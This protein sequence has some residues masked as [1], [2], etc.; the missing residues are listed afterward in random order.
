[1]SIIKP[2]GLT[3]YHSHTDY[4][5]GSEKAETMVKAAIEKGFSAWGISSHSPLPEYVHYVVLTHDKVGCYI[6]EVEMLKRK[7][8][9]QIEIYTAM[10]IDYIDEVDNP[11]NE[12]YQSL[13]LDY[14]IGA[15]HFIKQSESE[16][17]DVDTR[18]D[19]FLV[20]LERYY[21]NDLKR[22]VRDYFDTKM[23]MISTGGFD[24]VAHCD[25]ISQNATLTD[26]DITQQR[27][28]IDYAKEY[29]A[30]IAEQ[31]IM[32][33]VNTKSFEREVNLIFPNE[34]FW[35]FIYELGLPLVLNS[36]AHRVSEM[37]SGID[38]VKRGL[39][40]IGYKTLREFHSGK[41]YDVKIII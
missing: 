30:F 11:A 17:M 3:N 35:R 14:R 2:K 23:R 10:E 12:Y 5:D 24:F 37:T 1:M 13:P 25:K 39:K 16:A 18:H 28:Y 33:E 29:F 4:C 36:D 20:G 38:Y 27:W 15:V 8:A 19:K 21:S 9:D 7:Y 32:I 34:Q 22:L 26:P 41:W 31:E 40:E 6:D